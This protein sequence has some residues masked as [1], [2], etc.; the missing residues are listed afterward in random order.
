MFEVQLGEITSLTGSIHVPI[1][2]IL[3]NYGMRYFVNVNCFGL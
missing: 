3:L 1:Q 2:I